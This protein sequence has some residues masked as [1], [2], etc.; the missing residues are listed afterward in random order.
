MS[1]L[2]RRW[3]RAFT[4]VM[5]VGLTGCGTST[6]AY[7][8]VVQESLP[9]TPQPLLVVWR[10]TATHSGG[11]WLTL[12]EQIG[13]AKPVTLI[14]R[15]TPPTSIQGRAGSDLGDQAASSLRQDSAVLAGA[16][17]TWPRQALPLVPL[18]L[19]RSLP[20]SVHSYLQRS[21]SMP[22]QLTSHRLS[23]VV[24]LSATVAKPQGHLKQAL[25]TLVVTTRALHV[26][27]RHSASFTIPSLHWT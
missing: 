23:A 12:T 10:G 27:P 24:S 1:V 26:M 15:V 14:P 20:V 16:Q 5:A 13:H 8:V 11:R 7:H 3:A 22:I 9:S 4:A 17:K 18:S 6:P 21:W 2:H 25:W 19:M